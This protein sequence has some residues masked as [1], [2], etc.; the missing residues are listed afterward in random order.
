ML[1]IEDGN[2]NKFWIC[3]A[4]HFLY[5]LPIMIANRPYQ[6]D[7]T[8]TI[9][10][11]TGWNG[12]GRPL[13]ELIIEMFGGLKG[14]AL[15]VAP[16]PLIIA[17]AMLSYSLVIYY[18]NNCL[19]DGF[20]SATEASFLLFSFTI[21]PFLIFAFSYKFDVIT[22][23]LSLSIILCLFSI[24]IDN[25]WKRLGIS[26]I[27]GLIVFL[28][29]QASVG[30]AYSLFL[31]SFLLYLCNR[32]GFDDVKKDF[33]SCVGI[34]ISALV[35]KF[36]VSKFFILESNL[37]WRYKAAQFVDVTES[38]WMILIRKNLG[39]FVRYIIESVKDSI[40]PVVLLLVVLL[41]VILH[42][43][44]VYKIA[45]VAKEN[46]DVRIVFWAKLIFGMLLP[47]IILGVVISPLIFLVNTIVAPR[48]FFALSG[49]TM[50]LGVEISLVSETKVIVKKAGVLCALIV[51]FWAFSLMYMYGNAS[52][53][54]KQYETF[55]AQRMISDIEEIVQKEFDD[56]KDVEYIGLSIV[57]NTPRAPECKFLGGEYPFIDK[58]V[59]V[60]IN[61]DP[62]LGGPWLMHFSNQRIQFVT[63]S[64]DEISQ[65]TIYKN[66]VRENLIYNIYF[67]D[68][69]I[70]IVYNQ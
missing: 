7:V 60:Y 49:F 47:I 30:L 36:F 39:R 4:I 1:K 28:T 26:C 69:C 64:E 44:T 43:G 57:G 51:T 15:D 19:M 54:Q 6:D 25:T 53:S 65:A 22:M 23:I 46:K 31:I 55:L 34:S 58:L 33:M 37:D 11:L 3:F 5:T 2:K 17:I 20:A 12:D 21:N 70:F 40:S 32:R 9:K 52:Y 56:A 27:V 50:L 41:A 14:K 62:W 35:Y 48:L 29:Y 45:N 24:N 10:G 63:K 16:L 8:R 68:G 38:G 61:N 67:S 13:T 18:Q 66:C 59:P 42:I